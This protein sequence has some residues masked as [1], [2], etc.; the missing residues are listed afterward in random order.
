[1]ENIITLEGF[2]SVIETTKPI[3]INLFNEN[4]LLL[5][6]FELAGYK[7]LDDFLCDDEITKIK[8]K[9]MSAID[10][11]IDTSKND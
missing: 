1:M 3:T 5:I 4:D 10:V 8:F 6:S 11:Y 7:A 9:N 2:L